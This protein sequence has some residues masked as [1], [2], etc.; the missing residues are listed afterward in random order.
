MEKYIYIVRHAKSSWIDP[1]MS[2]HDRPLDDRG[3][4]D[5][6]MMAEVMLQSGYVID[7][8]I[9]STANRARST[10]SFFAEKYNLD[11][12]L[13]KRLYH[14]DPEDYLDEMIEQPESVVGLALF[15]HNPGITWLANM[16]KPGVTD[17]VPTC[18]V[19]VCTIKKEMSWQDIGWKDIH[20]A[21]ILSPKNPKS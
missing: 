14:G 16:L 17:N 20:L 10:A 1:M 21:H 4:H 18:G 19:L 11:V 7:K 5:A 2:D 6:P 12:N 8:I 15:G 9:A 3:W 13:A